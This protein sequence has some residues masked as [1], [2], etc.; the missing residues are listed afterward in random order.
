MAKS[1]IQFIISWTLGHFTR[2]ILINSLTALDIMGK[3]EGT[4]LF[5][6]FSTESVS[7]YNHSYSY[8]SMWCEKKQKSIFLES[9]KSIMRRLFISADNFLRLHQIQ[10]TQS[11]SHPCNQCASPASWLGR[12][13]ALSRSNQEGKANSSHHITHLKLTTSPR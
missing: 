10:K 7:I 9:F 12:A 13:S 4:P 5:L 1:A 6:D 3:T 2:L 11:P 8:I